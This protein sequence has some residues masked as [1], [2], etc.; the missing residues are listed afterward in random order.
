MK[1]SNLASLHSFSDHFQEIENM[2]HMQPV[3]GREI[4][5]K[6]SERKG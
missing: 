3:E 1:E 6:N 5:T 4:E 2:G